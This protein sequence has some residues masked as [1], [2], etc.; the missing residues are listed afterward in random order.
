MPNPFRSEPAVSAGVIMALVYI[1][2]AFGLPISPEQ[3]KTLED[4][5]PTVLIGISILVGS[6]RQMVFAPDTVDAL[7]KRAVIK[8]LTMARNAREEELGVR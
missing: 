2:I 8:G 1:L 6:I 3:Q 5:L 4:N 7:E